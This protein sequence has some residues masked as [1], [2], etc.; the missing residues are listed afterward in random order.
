MNL[1]VNISIFIGAVALACSLLV[2]LGMLVFR[3]LKRKNPGSMFLGK[4]S[5][6]EL[7]VI[8]LNLFALIAI[9]TIRKLSPESLVG[10]LLQSPFG[11]LLA[12]VVLVLFGYLSGVLLVVYRMLSSRI[13]QDAP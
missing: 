7:V 3:Y 6:S 13:G 2:V 11:L 4:V 5:P 12:F 1:I 10:A 9:L 8:G